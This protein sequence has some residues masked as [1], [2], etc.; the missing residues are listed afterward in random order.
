MKT[1]TVL[2]AGAGPTGLALALW[3]T[4]LG[5]AVRIIDRT[6]EAGT[7][8][9]ALAVQART[10]EFYQ[11]LGFADELVEG[12][13][14]VVGVNLWVRGAKAARVPLRDI[15]KGVTPFPFALVYPQD[16]H[17]RLLIAHLEALGVQVERETELVRFAQRADRVEAV[18]RKKDGSEAGCEAAYL[19]GCDGAS[20]TVRESLGIG[21]PGGTYRGRFYVADVE[22]SGRAIDDELHIDLD[23]ADLLLLF[24]M[25]GKGRVRLVGNVSRGLEN[26]SRELTFDDVS[27]RAIKHLGLTISK[28]NWFS[29]YRVHHRV[30]DR[31]RD[32]RVFLLGDAAHIH[33]P[34]G[35]QGMN[36]GIG[37]AVNLAWKIA[38][39]VQGAF[40]E[41]L[42][43][44]YEAER[45]AFARRLVATTDRGFT[46]ATKRGRVAAIVRA[47]IVPVIAPLLFRLPV[48]RRFFFRT[49]SQ[50]GIEYRRSRLSAGKAGAIHGGD[51]LPW[52]ELKSG[53][54]N[55]AP[56]TAL[57]WQ[58]HVYG[59]AKDDLA[60]A[61]SELRLALHVFDWRDEMKRAGFREDAAY[62]I[63]P[64]GYVAL[65][66]AAADTA[67]LRE[68]FVRLA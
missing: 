32:G 24:P 22:A 55:F 1:P 50:T 43:E 5:I 40:S 34:A 41:N 15:G 36:T 11:Q 67:R 48:L 59:K 68:Y 53:E 37:D 46:L 19:A 7:T 56:L 27:E 9:R 2:I 62:L 10:L 4:R 38:A 66:D 29:T 49:A 14:K 12:G 3:L 45:I 52:L 31:F 17:E 63:R 30:A 54:D 35:G 25:K 33:S 28:V 44:T 16:A 8:S 57:K 58:V 64:D 21:F 47:R 23:E 20:S 60:K 13:V 42:L 61:C 18:L 6:S 65:A 26:D 51:R 39:V